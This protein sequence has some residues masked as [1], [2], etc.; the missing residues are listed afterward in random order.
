[1]SRGIPR[2]GFLSPGGVEGFTTILGCHH[3]ILNLALGLYLSNGISSSSCFL[4][5]GMQGVLPGQGS[6][7]VN[8]LVVTPPPLPGER[9]PP[10]S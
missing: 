7:R 1:M 4:V 10:T 5:D 9:K 6:C 3:S 8:G 2:E